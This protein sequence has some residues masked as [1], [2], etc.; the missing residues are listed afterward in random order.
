[1]KN[2][3][4]ENICSQCEKSFRLE[5]KLYQGTCDDDLIYCDDCIVKNLCGCDESYNKHIER[6]QVWP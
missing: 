5:W 6:R 4:A 2:N 3:D 1:M